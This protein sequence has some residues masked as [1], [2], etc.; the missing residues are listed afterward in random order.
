M[1]EKLLK[2]IDFPTDIRQ[3]ANDELPLLAS[4]LREFIIDVVATKEGHFRC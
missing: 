3:L 1:P 4:E 2:N